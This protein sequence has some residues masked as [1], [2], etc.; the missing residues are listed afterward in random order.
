MN[1]LVPKVADDA[2]TFRNPAKVEVAPRLVTERLV[3]VVVPSV[4]LVVATR[5]GVKIL[6]EKKLVVVAAVPVA[7][8]KVR[9]WRL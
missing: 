9:P 7:E 5:F 8:V 4:A 2:V 6:L 1:V 3:R